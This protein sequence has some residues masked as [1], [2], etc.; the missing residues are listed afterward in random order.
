[1][2]IVD[3]SFSVGE[4]LVAEEDSVIYINYDV[5]NVGAKMPI[6]SMAAPHYEIILKA[7]DRGATELVDSAL[8]MNLPP[9]YYSAPMKEGEHHKFANVT[10]C[11]LSWIGE[12]FLLSVEI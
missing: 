1:M 7:D 9:E 12:G 5:I 11:S 10:V 8:W 3:F 4:R 6:P 2:Q